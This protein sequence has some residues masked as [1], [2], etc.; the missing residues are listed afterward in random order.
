MLELDITQ[1]SSTFQMVSEGSGWHS[2]LH[3]EG[4][5]TC[6]RLVQRLPVAILLNPSPVLTCLQRILACPALPG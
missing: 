1:G 2:A 5:G 6:I 3:K 4:N